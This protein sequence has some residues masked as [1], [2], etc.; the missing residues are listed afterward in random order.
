MWQCPYCDYI[1]KFIGFSPNGVYRYYYCPNCKKDFEHYDPRGENVPNGSW[2]IRVKRLGGMIWE[3]VG[4]N[5]KP[6]TPE[7]IVFS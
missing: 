1:L 6:F 4:L 5:P 2:K 7:V 3:W